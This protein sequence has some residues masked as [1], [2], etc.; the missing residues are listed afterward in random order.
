M[1]YF[2]GPTINALAPAAIATS[3]KKSPPHNYSDETRNET[4]QYPQQVASR[5]R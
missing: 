1:L 3:Q 2:D 5:S 4:R